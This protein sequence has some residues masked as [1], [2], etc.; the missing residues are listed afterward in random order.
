MNTD[1]NLPAT[2]NPA[3]LASAL[4]ILHSINF[5]TTSGCIVLSNRTLYSK[6]RPSLLLFSISSNTKVS[7]SIYTHP[8]S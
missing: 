5:V 2:T 1:L 7:G 6:R 4:F 8:R 3:W